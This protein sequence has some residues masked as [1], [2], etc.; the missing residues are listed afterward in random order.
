[1]L[2][3]SVGLIATTYFTFLPCFLFIFAGAPIIEKTQE[4]PR[5]KKVLEIITA[6]VLGVILNLTI[7]LTQ[8]VLLP[9]GFSLQRFDYMAAAWVVISIVAM[10]RFNIGMIWW[11]GA[12]AL[13]GLGRYF[14]SPF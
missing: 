13:F 12:S 8:A 3:G 14:L 11:I 10:Y 9:E 6:A 7:Y 5:I 4:N 1:M 2:A